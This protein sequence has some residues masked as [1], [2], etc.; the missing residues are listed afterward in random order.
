MKKIIKILVSGTLSTMILAS[1][2]LPVS[3]AEEKDKHPISSS[4]T[5]S[6][7]GKEPMFVDVDGKIIPEEEY[8]RTSESETEAVKETS[9]VSV[10]NKKSVFSTGANVTTTSTGAADSASYDLKNVYREST[11]STEQSSA[12][13]SY[14][15]YDTDTKKTKYTF[16][17]GSYYSGKF[18][19]IVM[20][21]GVVTAT[22]VCD[23]S[24]LTNNSDD[25]VGQ[26]TGT[27][28]VKRSSSGGMPEYYFGKKNGKKGSVEQVWAPWNAYR[29]NAADTAWVSAMDHNKVTK[30]VIDGSFTSVSKNAFRGFHGAL[31]N[32]TFGAKTTVINAYA[33]ANVGMK[34]ITWNGSKTIKEAAFWT[35]DNLTSL[36]FGGNA[37]TMSNPSADSST[38]TGYSYGVFNGCDSLTS[39]NFGTATTTIPI[40]CFRSCQKL[41]SITWGAVT[42]IKD[43]AFSA[44][45]GFT[46]LTLNGKLSSIGKRAFHK[47]LGTFTRVNFR[48]STLK[49]T[50]VE[51]FR[52]CEKLQI[53][54]FGS[55]ITE[56][57]KQCFYVDTALTT[58]IFDGNVLTKIGEEAFRGCSALKQGTATTKAADVL[59][60][61][62][63]K[64]SGLDVNSNVFTIPYSVSNIEPGAFQNCYSLRAVAWSNISSGKITTIKHNTFTNC[65]G[66][67]YFV[68][69]NSLTTIEGATDTTSGAFRITESGIDEA[70]T[71]KWSRYNLYL[72][73]NTPNSKLTYIN[74]NAFSRFEI[75]K[76]GSGTSMGVKF[77]DIQ[78]LTDMSKNKVIAAGD[79]IVFKNIKYIG[80]KAFFNCYTLTGILQFESYVTISSRAFVNTSLTDLF[81]KWNSA[82]S[83]QAAMTSSIVGS[84]NEYV[85]NNTNMG[86]T[87]ST[88]KPPLGYQSLYT[89][90]KGKSVAAHGESSKGLLDLWMTY[91]SKVKAVN[92]DFSS[93]GDF[94]NNELQYVGG[95]SSEV[96]SSINGLI[97]PSTYGNWNG[98]VRTD[99]MTQNDTISYLRTD[100]EWINGSH[101]TARETVHFGYKN[102]QRVDYIFVVDNSPSMDKASLNADQ[103]KSELGDSFAYGTSNVSKTMNTF[104]VIYDIATKVLVNDDES[105]HENTL[106][107]ISFAGSQKNELKN[108]AM[109]LGSEAMTS[110]SQVYNALFKT[111]PYN[112]GSATNYSSGL[113]AAYQ[114]AAK[115]Q[116][117]SSNKQIVVLLTDGAPTYYTPGN[118]TSASGNTFADYQTNG[119]DWAAAIRDDTEINGKLSASSRTESGHTIYNSSTKKYSVHSYSQS[120]YYKD[121]DGT[122]HQSKTYENVEGLGIDIY[123]IL[124]GS[125]KTDNL[126]MV[127]LGEKNKQSHTYTSSNMKTFADAFNKI[128][129]VSTAENYSVVVPLDNNFVYKPNSKVTVG[130]QTDLQNGEYQ[131]QTCTVENL[132]GD[133]YTAV[134]DEEAVGRVFYDGERNAVIW[135]LGKTTMSNPFS[136]SYRVYRLV[137]DMDY[138]GGGTVV[139]GVSASY[140]NV[141]YELGSYVAVNDNGWKNRSYAP[142]YI[143]NYYS[144]K[145][146]NGNGSNNIGG[147]Y[148][149]LSPD[150]NEGTQTAHAFSLASE[151]NGVL[152]NIAAPVYLPAAELNITKT[153]ES[154]NT[155]SGAEF[156]IYQDTDSND[157]Y[158]KMSFESSGNTNYSVNLTGNPSKSGYTCTTTFKSNNN[159]Y[160]LTALAPGTYYVYESKYPTS[161]GKSYTSSA[162]NASLMENIWTEDGR[163]LGCIKVVVNH[164]PVN[165][166]VNAKVY[167]NEVLYDT[168]SDGTVSVHIYNQVKSGNIQGKK[169]DPEGNPVSGAVFALYASSTDRN[170]DKNRLCEAV[171]GNDGTFTFSV[172]STGTYYWREVFIPNGYT[173]PVTMG[174]IY[175]PT[176]SGTYT[177]NI[178]EVINVPY[179]T[180]KVLVNSSDNVRSGFKF[181]LTSSYVVD[182]KTKTGTTY[183]ATTGSSGEYIFARVPIYYTSYNGV[184]Y[185]Y[186]KADYTIT[187]SGFND[188]AIPVRYFTTEYGSSWNNTASAESYHIG[189]VKFNETKSVYVYNPSIR[190]R[191]HNY[192]GQDKVTPL[193]SQFIMNSENLTTGDDGSVES[194]QWFGYGTHNL[195]QTKVPTGYN[196]QSKAVDFN[197]SNTSSLTQKTS[198][199]GNRYY[200]YNLTV[201]NSRSLSIPPTGGN[202]NILPIIIGTISFFI[203]MASLIVLLK[204][205]EN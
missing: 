164:I 135:H 55:H 174:S 111:K 205:Q 192:D 179:S 73:I 104:S 121:D 112:E 120:N 83:K 45:N 82:R 69:P 119:I 195:T 128:I 80:Q 36:N 109:T 153:D 131:Y 193:Q 90:L 16:K 100:A 166:V 136:S 89:L 187:E 117:N 115:R 95:I 30:I 76:N 23:E 144:A 38:G 110:A 18:K 79:T 199:T 181:S 48:A 160:N 17:N 182:G 197:L 42:T 1:C 147:A 39:V 156:E 124:I 6:F 67:Q 41:N 137:F 146:S 11:S 170:T 7:E 141:R 189:T 72:G 99:P 143:T 148:A 2:I 33:F 107:V 20:T 3:A 60:G 57:S 126:N 85:S 138:R 175:V 15:S 185:S 84:S 53:A 34:S 125:S 116:K 5:V 130:Y 194:A 171:S 26:G 65:I 87:D 201:Y 114:L 12:K 14:Y 96:S 157:K 25:T 35:C 127:T 132:T 167:S 123:G 183:T 118:V 151:N 9:I 142:S 177:A 158:E 145:P 44:I 10:K 204:H 22:W 122:V 178:G 133:M 31:E 40:N 59:Y 19:K 105:N 149:Y 159:L 81:F 161:G 70:A 71:N 152:R 200:E 50:G 49:S 108:S 140:R 68:V 203:V 78:N 154:N 8:I 43:Y 91:F 75:L 106:S 27:M 139:K 63:S 176:L 163:N 129:S 150:Y 66:M 202:G 56:I 37:M 46:T 88:Y 191:I 165:R 103:D 162:K 94:F 186:H 21:D 134:A 58:A 32:V 169:V 155:L 101:A 180:I 62:G 74:D 28:T 54:D 52:G 24:S 190:V 172:N 13:V 173:A 184:K 86:Y 4:E 92:S 168:I 198:G 97:P 77:Y 47:C 196:L 188:G 61:A 64:L 29:R 98:S 51:A 93:W 102:Q 113:A